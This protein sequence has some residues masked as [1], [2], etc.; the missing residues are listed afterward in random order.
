[1]ESLYAI[2]AGLE[3]MILLPQPSEHWDYRYS[4]PHLVTSWF[5]TRVLISLNG[6]KNTAEATGCIFAKNESQVWEG[7]M[8]FF[9]FIVVLGGGTC[10]IFK[11]SYNVSNISYLNSSL[12]PLLFILPPLDSWKSFNRYH[13]CIY[14]HVYAFFAL[15]SPSYPLSHHLSPS[16]WCHTLP[17]R[18]CSTLL[19]SD[20]VKEKR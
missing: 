11:D 12:P 19:F 9:S 14:I 7:E 17:C 10:G 6:K 8:I 3:F 4:P 1:M 13:F 15:Y 16:H 20:S 5:L 18:T 2:Q